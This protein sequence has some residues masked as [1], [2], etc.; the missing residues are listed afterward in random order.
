MVSLFVLLLL[1]SIPSAYYIG[2]NT[3]ENKGAY[4]PL[5]QHRL[6]NDPFERMEQIHHKMD[7]MFDDFWNDPFLSYSYEFPS[8]RDFDTF[9]PSTSI[10]H[11]MTEDEIIIKAK[12]PVEDKSGVNVTIT[13]EG[14]SI[15]SVQEKHA[16][17]RSDEYYRKEIQSQQFYRYLS[18]PENAD[19][20]NAVQ[21]FDN[22]NLEIKIPFERGDMNE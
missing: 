20:S 6:S 2:K 8:I 17:K 7:K 13:E 15:K 22:G 21:T 3:K 16:E 10:E 12:L 14:V 9:M 1:V 4:L 19:T 11:Y 18:L 5:S